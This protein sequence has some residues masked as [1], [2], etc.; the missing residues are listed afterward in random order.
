[1]LFL[2]SIEL[3]LIATPMGGEGEG[4]KEGLLF[5]G[6]AHMFETQRATWQCEH[7]KI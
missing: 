2:K 6:A 4:G 7:N 3:A 5:V 1:M